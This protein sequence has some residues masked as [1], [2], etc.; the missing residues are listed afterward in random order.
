VDQS[1]A[2]ASSPLVVAGIDVSK[3]KLDVFVD[4]TAAA[5]SFENTPRGIEQLLGFLS[6]LQVSLV[7]IEATGRYERAAAVALMD[8]GMEVA[9]INPRQARDFAKATGVLAKTDSVD[10][11]LLANFGR[12]IGPRPTPRPS[13]AQLHLEALVTRRR[14]VVGMRAMELNR[15]QQTT[16]KLALGLVKSHLRQ[17]DSQIEKIEKQ[18]ARLIQ[19]NDDWRGKSLLIQSVPGIGPATAGVLLAELPELGSFDAKRIASISG[20]APFA[21][22]SGTLKNTR[23]IRGGRATVRTSLYMATLS[24]IRC[25]PAIKR[26]AQRLK[27]TGKCFK[28][29]ITACMRKLLITLNAIVKSAKPWEDRCL[30]TN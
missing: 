26:F 17:L 20:L 25:N 24:A 7:V 23:R 12:C 4:L 2:S 8:A 13:D 19:R 21:D 10:A 18:I 14:Q 6:P 27:E 3:A 1:I 9:V 15:S 22:E 28:Q 5:E 29:M 11:R 30:E 16:D